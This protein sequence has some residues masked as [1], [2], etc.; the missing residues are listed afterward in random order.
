MVPFSICDVI[1]SKC[2]GRT[3]SRLACMPGLS[4]MTTRN[5]NLPGGGA[6]MAGFATGADED[7]ARR[8]VRLP[9]LGWK[10]GSRENDGVKVRVLLLD[11]NVD[12]G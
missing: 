12:A 10:K 3:S 2:L 9:E 8:V 4:G 11:W 1:P 5:S 7:M 6:V